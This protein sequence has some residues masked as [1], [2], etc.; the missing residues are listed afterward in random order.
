MSR[1]SPR[2]TIWTPCLTVSRWLRVSGPARDDLARIAAYTGRRWGPAQRRKYLALIKERI[3]ALRG[4][5]SLA[6]RRD[7]L[8]PGL[9]AMPLRSHVI[10]YR[11][12]ETDVDIL[13]VLH[14]GMDSGV[15]RD[16]AE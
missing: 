16:D 13:R 14:G 15:L 8:M 12:T 1:K 2:T 9:R 11:E 6:P 3:N 7:D 5:A 4:A 10:F